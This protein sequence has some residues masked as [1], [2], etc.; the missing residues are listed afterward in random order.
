MENHNTE[1]MRR[2]ALSIGIV[3][4]VY[5]IADVKLN[6]EKD[7]II[8]GIP[9]LIKNSFIIGIGLVLVSIYATLRY[10]YF[11]II[12]GI[13][14][15]KAR[16]NLLDNRLPDGTRVTAQSTSPNYLDTNECKDIL[17]KEVD[18]YFPVIRGEERTYSDATADGTVYKFQIEPKKYSSVVGRLHSFDHWLPFWINFIA[19][20]VFISFLFI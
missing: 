20:I 13:T 16:D 11:G 12:I 19:I 10:L 1:K 18:K 17:Q 6:L 9:L 5:A 14:P 4:L 2:F 3:L 15:K 7:I 8:L